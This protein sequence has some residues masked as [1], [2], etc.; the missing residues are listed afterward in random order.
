MA[1][2]EF[3]FSAGATVSGNATVNDLVVTVSL[4]LV[5]YFSESIITLASSQHPLCPTNESSE[6]YVS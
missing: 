2:N 6:G 3:R 4:T 5:K 1:A